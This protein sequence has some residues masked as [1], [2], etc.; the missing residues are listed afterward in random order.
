[1]T[2]LAIAV[3]SVNV[4]AVIGLPL[5]GDVGKSDNFQI[6]MRPAF[7]VMTGRGIGGHPV[8]AGL[9]GLGDSP[10]N[11]ASGNW[12]RGEQEGILAAPPDWVAWGIAGPNYASGNWRRGEQEGILAVPPD[13]A[14]RGIA[15][16]NYASGNWR[17]GEQEGMWTGR[18]G[19]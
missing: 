7:A 14:V 3:S 13:W 11:Y 9:G 10:P 19:G 15:G 8:G 1:M 18:F 17:R 5:G 2:T 16:P 4:W 6:S 12:R